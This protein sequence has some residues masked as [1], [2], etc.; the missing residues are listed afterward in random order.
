MRKLSIRIEKICSTLHEVQYSSPGQTTD[1]VRRS[2]VFWTCSMRFI[3]GDHA[4]YYMCCVFF[5][6]WA[7][8]PQDEMHDVWH[9]HLQVRKH[10]WLQHT[11]RREIWIYC[12][13]TID[14]SK[15]HSGWFAGLYVR[16]CSFRSN[17]SIHLVCIVIVPVR[18]LYYFPVPL[19]LH[20]KRSLA[21]HNRLNQVSS[22]KRT[23]L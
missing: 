23:Y 12:L 7:Y 21:S 18:T 20:T 3:S 16:L 9:N 10:Q 11:L 6:F 1:A 22:E 2:I 5:P 19:S 17:P 4:G 15:C 14:P 8:S 13:H